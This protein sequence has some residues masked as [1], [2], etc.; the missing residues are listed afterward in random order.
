MDVL[1]DPDRVRKYR[2]R[3]DDRS[4]L[5]PHLR[6]LVCV[7]VARWIPLRWSPNLVSLIANGSSIATFAM[8]VLVFRPGNE[9]QATPYPSLL[10]AVGIALYLVLDNSDGLHARRLG[11]SSPLGDFIDH[12]LDSFSAFMIP[13]GILWMLHVDGPTSLAVVVLSIL[14]F[15]MANWEM[16]ETGV[17]RLP[18]FGEVE[19]NVLAI[20][21]H[22]VAA[23]HGR[24]IFYRDVMGVEIVTAL[25]ALV[26]VGFASAVMQSLSTHR[27]S[28]VPMLGAA[29]SLAVHGWWAL[30]VLTEGGSAV[31]CV[32][33]ALIVGL[34]GVKH[35][36]D[37]QRA[38][39]LGLALR[40]FDGLLMLQGL[41][42]LA[43]VPLRSAIGL[44]LYTYVSAAALAVLCLKLTYQFVHTWRFVAARIDT[45]QLWVRKGSVAG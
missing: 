18:K 23:I 31:G 44:D 4:I 28:L 12:W 41:S 25:T 20:I 8:L 2:Y 6:R 29:C 39:L 21:V 13:L 3:C 16:K 30:L 15:W 32:L 22:L 1:L 34:V 19:G 10:A 38:H 27:G 35:I 14:A 37:V 42:L 11:L 36:G 43:S 45:P 24:S 17:L 5:S 9:L 7:H 33:P 26:C 40:P